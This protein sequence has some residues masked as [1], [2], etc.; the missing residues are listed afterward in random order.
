MCVYVCV[1][2]VVCVC[3][4]LCL[5]MSVYE[6]YICV[7]ICVHG[8][9]LCVYV[10]S[11]CVVCWCVWAGIHLCMCPVH[12]VA[13]CRTQVLFFRHH[14]PVCL[15]VWGL[16][17]W[18]PLRVCSLGYTDWLVRQNSPCFCFSALKLQVCPPCLAFFCGIWR[19]NGFR[20]A[21]EVLCPP[22][23]LPSLVLRQSLSLSL[24]LALSAGLAR[25]LPS[26]HPVLGSVPWLQPSLA[27]FI[28]F[29][30]FWEFKLTSIWLH[31]KYV[32]HWAISIAPC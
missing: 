10:C 13:K 6:V 23:L 1:G 20:A 18:F 29:C 7:C 26:I 8:V 21:R 28:F 17:H 19:S 30:G 22:S 9:Y 5:C 24:G 2:Y 16:G 27:I 32:T 15:F 12:V 31:S 25:E 3:V 14:L 11:V 4:L